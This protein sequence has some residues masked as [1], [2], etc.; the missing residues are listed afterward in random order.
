MIHDVD[1]ARILV[2][3]NR[4]VKWTIISQFNEIFRFFFGI[5]W[6][7]YSYF[8]AFS[9]MWAHCMTAADYQDLIDRGEAVKTDIFHS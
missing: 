3:A 4:T 6:H 9:G 1:I 5:L 2:Q 8:V 7:F